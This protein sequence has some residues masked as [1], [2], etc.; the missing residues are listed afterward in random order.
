MSIEGDKV[1]EASDLCYLPEEDFRTRIILI[2]KELRMSLLQ[3]NR[4]P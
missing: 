3:G 2:S 1:Q 4:E